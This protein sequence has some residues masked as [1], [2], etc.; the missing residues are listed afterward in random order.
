MFTDPSKQNFYEKIF[1]NFLKN[2]KGVK[3]LKFLDRKNGVYIV[4][5]EIKN[6]KD[7]KE[8]QKAD[9]PKQMDFSF[10]YYNLP[11]VFLFFI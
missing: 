7:I 5:Q 9:L 2:I 10:K 6:Q 4:N 3:N 8:F 1:G 11:V